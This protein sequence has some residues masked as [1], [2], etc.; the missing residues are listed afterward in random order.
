[1]YLPSTSTVGSGLSATPG[2]ASVAVSLAT[3]TCT[4]QLDPSLM[5]EHIEEMGFD[6]M[7]SDQVE[8]QALTRANEVWSFAGVSF[9]VWYLLSPFFNTW[10]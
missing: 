6:A 3:E 9:G 7:P 8:I 4:V 10:V 2:I 1:M 5:V